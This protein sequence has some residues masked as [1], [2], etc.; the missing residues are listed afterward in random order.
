MRRFEAKGFFQLERWIDFIKRLSWEDIRRFRWVGHLALIGLMAYLSSSILSQ[1]V[2]HKVSPLLE[3]KRKEAPRGIEERELH[4]GDFTSIIDT[5]MFNPG[6]AVPEVTEIIPGAPQ[7][8]DKTA[9]IPSQLPAD[10]VGTITLP[11]PDL[12][13]AS[14]RD[15]ATNKTLIYRVNDQFSGKATVVSIDRKKVYLHNI[16]TEKLEYIEIKEAGVKIQTASVVPAP[17]APTVEGVREVGPGRY[18]VSKSYV[19]EAMRNFGLVLTQARVVPNLTE[20]GKVRGFKIFAI[21]PDSLYD[22]L[23]LKDND[24]L[25]NINNV[26][27]DDPAKGYNIFNQLRSESDITINV[28]RDGQRQTF[29]Y[30]IR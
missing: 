10:L 23:K 4:R 3:L 7:R 9:A 27:L 30:N 24:I 20:D 13:I 17:G 26:T 29:R 14:I 2:R 15:K 1:Y 22:K 19:D 21:K 25:L 28:E 11:N 8:F 18:V 12:S 16:E 6:A 5:N